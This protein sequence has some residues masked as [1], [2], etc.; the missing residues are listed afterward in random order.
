MGRKPCC[1]KVGLKRGAWT[2]EEDKKLLNF[3]LTN[4]RC[5]WRAVP[6]LAGL[7]RCGKS[8]RL[9]WTNYLRPDLKRGLLSEEE[10]KLVIDLHCHL[11]NRWSKIA[12]HLPGR[13]D[14]EI[15]NHWNTHIKKKLSKMGIDPLT[16]KP[17]ASG[18][19]EHHQANTPSGSVS[20]GGEDH[21]II[22]NANSNNCG[23]H[24][25]PQE[26][27]A[28]SSTT[29]LDHHLIDSDEVLQK[30]PNFST[31]EVPMIQPHEIIVPCSST[32]SSS[33]NSTSFN[34]SSSTSNSNS[35]VKDH[36]ERIKFPCMEWPESMYFWGLNDNCDLD[37]IFND[38]T[39]K[40]TLDSTLSQCQRSELDQELWNQGSF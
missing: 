39:G 15:K 17:I 9:R 16:H 1:D 22:E 33:A 34:S 8:C 29:Q 5:L 37:W 21:E 35:S 31:N 40:V 14:N 4:G 18:D 13:T 26:E 27:E 10:E 2:A 32:T 6:K 24:K 3:M 12:S 23:D 38:Y 11:G 25:L 19:H 30:S 28:K 20:E 36:E 7:L